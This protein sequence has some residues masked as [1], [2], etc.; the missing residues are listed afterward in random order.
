MNINDLYHYK[1]AYKIYNFLK[2]KNHPNLIINYEFNKKNFITTILNNLYNIK[3]KNIF[4]DNY[5]YN[6]I[7]YY[8]D[9]NVIKVDL[10]NTFIKE[11]YSII[12]SYNYYKD[13][14]NYVIVDNYENINNILEN[15]L[16]VIVEK[17]SKTTKFIF[18]TSNINNIESTIKS[19]FFIINIPNL[20]IYDKQKIFLK[21]KNH[22]N[23]NNIIKKNDLNLIE[24]ELDNFISPLDLFFNKC[25]QIFNN[26]IDKKLVKIRELSYNIKISIIDFTELQKKILSHYLQSNISND[27]KTKLISETCKNNYLMIKCYKDIIYIELYFLQVYNIL[28]D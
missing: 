22:K 4:T 23:F 17:Y 2:F 26:K 6:N 18:L 19:R 28:N 12:N 21:H 20:T 8:F 10:K 24:K 7:Y 25:I 5:E 3:T 1:T 14:Y 27:I 13:E 9:A 15:K 16:K 11:I